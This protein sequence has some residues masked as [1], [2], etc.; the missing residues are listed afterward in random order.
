M[1]NPY[2]SG[3]HNPP[4]NSGGFPQPPQSSY[5]GGLQ[6]PGYQPGQQYPSNQNFYIGYGGVQPPNNGLAIASMVVSLVSVLTLCFWGLG[7]LLALLG[8]IF[9]HVS[10]GQI[11]RDG[12]RGDGMAMAGIVIGYCVLGLTLLGIVLFVIGLSMPFMTGD[13]YTTM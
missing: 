8:V 13:F 2:G 6:Y 11:R 5:G 10:R 3:P 4:S 9:G 1:T 12:T 7:V